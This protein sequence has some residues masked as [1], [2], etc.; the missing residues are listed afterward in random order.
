VPS[1]FI[2]SNR[3]IFL[4]S[5]PKISHKHSI[6]GSDDIKEH[7]KSTSQSKSKY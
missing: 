6:Y 2:N 4:K 3:E 5:Q 7:M 1:P